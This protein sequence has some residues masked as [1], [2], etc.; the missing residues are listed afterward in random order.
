MVRVIGGLEFVE[1]QIE[2]PVCANQEEDLHDGVVWGDQVGGEIQVAGG[3]HKRKQK[4]TLP[5]DSCRCDVVLRV[6]K[7]VQSGSGVPLLQ[8]FT[9]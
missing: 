7:Y 9:K 2:S 3:K 1:D 4:L 6:V 5:R 8:G